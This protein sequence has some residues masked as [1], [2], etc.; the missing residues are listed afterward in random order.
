MSGWHIREEWEVRSERCSF[1]RGATWG[2]K[3]GFV[4]GVSLV[5]GGLLLQLWAGPVEWGALAWPVNGAVLV[6]LLAVI[7][8]LYACGAKGAVFGCDGIAAY[9]TGGAVS[10]LAC[11]AVL[12]LAMGLTRQEEGG[13]WLNDMT[14]FWPFV[15]T[16]A[17]AVVVLGL[18]TVGRVRRILGCDGIA[19]YRTGGAVLGWRNAAFVLSHA[20][21]FVALTAA[22]LGHADMQRVKMTT[23]TGVREWRAVDGH[24]GVKEMPL[25]IELQRFIMETYDDGSPRRIASEIMVETKG[26]RTARAVVDVN[27]PYEVDGWRIYQYGYDTQKGAESRV[28]VLELVSD[29]WLPLV[30]TGFYMM[31]AGA[32]CLFFGGR[33]AKKWKYGWVLSFAALLSLVFIS[34][35]VFE[36]LFLS[37]KLMPA[38]QSPWFAPHV[39]VYMFAYAVLGVATLMAAYLLFAKRRGATKDMLATVDG[40]VG[41]GLSSLT[42]G[43]LFGAFWAKEAWGHYWSWDPKE[44][45]AAVT[46]LAY[47]VYVHYRLV[48]RHRERLALWVLIV[49]FALL[50]M[51]WWGVNYLP[52]ARAAS[53]HTYNV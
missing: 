35:Y 22:A 13:A 51:C 42:V 45:W 32:V 19:A 18:A 2:L 9:R 33:Q 24:G 8:A 3:E 29:P 20:G 16:Y 7:A 23:A 36:P 25:T 41:L 30:Y 21:L 6:G 5:L 53:V 28:S 49:S 11:A 12:T 52:S 44:T 47:L 46:W 27:R 17:Y 40:L 14:S 48:P 26:G 1:G 31:L 38:L 34:E 43:M 10:S 39:V 15:L 50:Q 37:R 4:V